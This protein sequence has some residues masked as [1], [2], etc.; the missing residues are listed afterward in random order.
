MRIVHPAPSLPAPPRRPPSPP[1]M[2]DLLGEAPTEDFSAGADLLAEA[3]GPVRAP[4]RRP[5]PCAA[6]CCAPKAACRRRRLCATSMDAYAA[7]CRLPLQPPLLPAAAACCCPACAA[8]GFARI[9]APACVCVLL[10]SELAGRVSPPPPEASSSRARPTCLA[11]QKTHTAHNVA[12]L[13]RTHTHRRRRRH[14]RR[15]HLAAPARSPARPARSPLSPPPP[16]RRRRR[17]PLR[18]PFGIQS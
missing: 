7:A 10:G 1:A 9:H 2:E 3:A 4:G 17:R 8:A 5:R 12:A 6:A 18:A 13:A 11:P 16:S 15:H 14:R